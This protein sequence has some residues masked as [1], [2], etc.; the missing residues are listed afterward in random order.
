MTQGNVR[1]MLVAFASGSDSDVQVNATGRS[2]RRR[3]VVG[4]MVVDL[5]VSGVLLSEEQAETYSEHIV[6]LLP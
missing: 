1:T 4:R 5:P 3:I 6:E 2:H